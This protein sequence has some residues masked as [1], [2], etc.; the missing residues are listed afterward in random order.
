M[1]ITDSLIKRSCSSTIYRRGMEYFKEGRV[2]LRK[3]EDNLI[4]AVVDGESLY[5]VMVKFEN[6]Y[7]R[8]QFCTCPYY[9]TMG[10]T[11]KHIVATLK[12][13]QQE[14]EEGDAFVDEND[15]L[16]ERL[17]EDFANISHPK[18]LLHAKFTLY[19]SNSPSHKLNF[20]MSVEMGEAGG[21]MHGIENF[22]DRY[23]NNKNFTIDKNTKF[24]SSQ[25]EFP[26][27]QS[28][29]I[30]ILAETY[31]NRSA[32]IFLY[33]KASYQIPFGAATAKRILA[34]LKNTGFTLVF[35]GMR[36][37][38]IRIIESDPDIVVDINACDGEICLSMS[39]KGSLLIPDGSY[40]LHENIIYHTT[41]NWR[42]Y[43]VP[44]YNSLIADGRTQIS[45]RGENKT[46]FAANVLPALNG[47]HGVVTQGID[48]IIINEKPVFEVYFD[49]A[50]RNIKAVVMAKYGSVSVRLPD[51]NGNESKIIIHDRNAEERILSFFMDFFN[52]D[53]NF[54]LQDDEKIYNFLKFSLP[55]LSNEAKVLT[56]SAF[57]R[58][59][60]A[61]NTNISASL[62]YNKKLNL[63]E[64]DFDSDIPFDEMQGILNAIKL[65][66][67]FYR[68]NDGSF[69]DFSN[70]SETELFDVIN[71]LEFTSEDLKNRHKFIPMY[72][73]LYLNAVD[74]V[75]KEKSF[76]DY[77][78]NIKAI[79]PE[80][81]HQL[82]KVLR[83]YQKDGVKWLK[84]LDSLGLGGI[85]ADDMGL[86]KTLQVIAF[87]CSQNPKKPA[88]VV[89]PSALTYNW[90]NEIKTFMPEEKVL[91]IDGNREERSILIKNVSDYRFIITSYPI[92][93][94]DINNFCK[95]DFSYCFIDEAQYIKN[96]KTMNAKSVKR[97]IAERKFALT[98]TPI[99]NSLTELWSIFDF[100][101]SGYLGT[102]K[103]FRDNYEIPITKD[104]NSLAMTALKTKVMPFIMRRVKKDVLSELPDKME[105]TMFAELE[106]E[107]KQMY[108]SFL[109][110]AKG[111]TLSLL[112][113]GGKGKMQILTLLMRL[114]Q[115]C[116]HPALFD[117]N[118]VK[119]SGKLKLLSELVTNAI[120]SGH[121]LLI[122]SQYTSML[123]IIKNM[124]NEKNIKSFYLDGKTP[125]YERLEMADR[126]NGGERSVFLISLRAGGTGLNLTGAD[127]V[128]HY[129]PWWNPAAMDQASDRAYRIGQ[130]KD[131]QVIKLV[132]KGTIEEKIMKLQEAK[133]SLADDIIKVSG[134]TL[135]A[136]SN[137]EIISL[138]EEVSI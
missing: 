67:N 120:D 57:D 134:D 102:L 20:G 31:E 103:S 50:G 107:Q 88:L 117:E 54:I 104:G 129:D 109:Q 3:R 106:P 121:R 53:G 98:G 75:K 35:D 16:A 27:P 1:E 96:P 108:S 42:E 2:H 91:I 110:L 72:N 36:I 17:C 131:V 137:E 63:L 99:E 21:A 85:L 30:D 128:I 18:Q 73:S 115:I 76:S 111:Q 113:S 132:S 101:M 68:M 77:I 70:N 123:E 69:L 80:I 47:R 55:M 138:F 90:K 22:L 79:K 81:P 46:L 125:A 130:T 48:E 6:G 118:Y 95:I 61:A 14:L 114:R 74:S 62:R 66:Q 92:L 13:R 24:I 60:K 32:D 15:R 39:D 44:I 78:D 136:L 23:S 124:L 5:N 94:R 65:K 29:I 28:E 58:F 127:M 59:V 49:A 82:E 34:L 26:Y 45:F 135:S 33:P 119:E 83:E 126:F 86:G 122:F 19:I 7:I 10:S 40:F 56:S 97:I 89:V 100:I 38:D 84:Q 64:T 9:E 37:P 71:R 93:R 11:C 105:Y 116:C 133:R 51:R 52:K 87:V 41:E 43:F 25:T 12:Q 4:T 112:N 8:D